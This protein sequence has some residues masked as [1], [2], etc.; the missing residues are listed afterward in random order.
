MLLLN[1]LINS[2]VLLFCIISF[3]NTTLA[4]KD[5]QKKG[6]KPK[7]I[8]IKNG[9]QDQNVFDKQLIDVEPSGRDILVENAAYYRNTKNRLFNGTILGYVTPVC[10]QFTL[11]LY[12]AIYLY[13]FFFKNVFFYN[14]YFV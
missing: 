5:R 10:I 13:F 8:I 4:P 6:Q 7:D 1:S 3:A 2:I 11:H 12:Y 9:P 14:I